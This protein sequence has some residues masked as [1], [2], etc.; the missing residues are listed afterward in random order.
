[1][2]FPLQLAEV[3]VDDAHHYSRANKLR[4][5]LTLTFCCWN[6][7]HAIQALRTKNVCLKLINHKT[8]TAHLHNVAP[9][10]VIII[11]SLFPFQRCWVHFFVN[12]VKFAVIFAKDR[13]I[14][15]GYTQTVIFT[16]HVALGGVVD[17][18]PFKHVTLKDVVI[19]DIIIDNKFKVLTD[20]VVVRCNEGRRVRYQKQN[21]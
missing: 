3:D 13:K 2:N 11:N 19:D 15:H 10:Q 4:D 12:I 6:F 9:H 1:M 16:H 17:C 20:Y 14:I 7:I 5:R 21:L 18:R 8:S